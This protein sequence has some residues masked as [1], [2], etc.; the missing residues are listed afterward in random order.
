MSSSATWH[1]QVPLPLSWGILFAVCSTATLW[2]GTFSPGPGLLAGLLYFG[3]TPFFIVGM[4]FN[5]EQQRPIPMG[6]VLVALAACYFLLGFGLGALCRR[7]K[8]VLR[9]WLLRTGL[10]PYL[11]TWI[12][13]VGISFLW[14]VIVCSTTSC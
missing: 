6:P 11:V 4:W 1:L 14:L 7:S 10:L 9:I 2:L 13:I 3:H 12:V 8:V 5:V